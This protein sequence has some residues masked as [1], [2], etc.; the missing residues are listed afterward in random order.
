VA[1]LAASAKPNREWSVNT[2]CKTQTV[3]G[4][5]PTRPQMQP[6]LLCMTANPSMIC[7]PL[8]AATPKRML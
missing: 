8:H 6:H 7:Q 1:M 3:A 2:T 4:R 5:H